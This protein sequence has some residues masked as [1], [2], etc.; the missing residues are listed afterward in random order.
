MTVLTPHVPRGTIVSLMDLL[1]KLIADA[2]RIV[3]S[4]TLKGKTEKKVRYITY[5]AQNERMRFDELKQIE[6]VLRQGK[7]LLQAKIIEQ[8][9]TEEALLRAVK[10]QEAI[11]AVM[12]DI[13]YWFDPKGNLVKWNKKM[14]EVTGLSPEELSGRNILTFVPDTDKAAVEQAFKEALEKG[15][16]WVEAQMVAKD[17]NLLPYNFSAAALKDESGQIVGLTGV[18]RDISERKRFEGQLL[19]WTKEI[20]VANFELKKLINAVEQAAEAILVTDLKGR[21]QYVN[22]AFTVI[23]GY[24]K[25]EALGKT[26]QILHSDQNPPGLFNK[27][28]EDILSGRIWKGT[29]INRKKTGELYY[30]EMTVTPVLD[31]GGKISNFIALKKDVTDRVRAEEELQRKNIELGDAREMADTANKAKSEFLANMSHELRTPLNAVIGF[32]DML[33]LGMTGSL[34]D[35]QMHYIRDIYESGRHLLSLINDILDLSKIEAG[36]MSAEYAEIKVKDLIEYSL[37][38]L[39]EKA[40]KHNIKMTTDLEDDM[41]ALEADE[42]QVKQVLVNLLSNAVKFTPDGGSVSVNARKRSSVSKEE[43]IPNPQTPNPDRAFIEISVEDSGIGIKPED[44]QKLFQPFQ[45]LRSPYNKNYKGTG[46]GLALCKKI[47]ELHGGRIW[48]ESAVG[49]GSRFIFTLPQKEITT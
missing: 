24:S 15:A 41:L 47:V 23:S 14:E 35:K 49:K 20:E 25:E 22:P 40:L 42:M 5:M 1:L 44:I 32:S 17:G 26:P 21:I 31:S 33:L 27:M 7:E 37:M 36:K 30:E 34:T 46:L 45:Q 43:P 16:G 13:F 39:K 29:V 48:A 3:I 8:R 9:K 18:G 10:E 12:M 19:E 28:W 2:L 11:M 6:D 4:F 38:F